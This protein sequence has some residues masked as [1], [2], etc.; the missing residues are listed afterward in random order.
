MKIILTLALLF[1]FCLSHAQTNTIKTNTSGIVIYR[2]PEIPAAY[3]GGKGEWF[4][5]LSKN[6]RY[7]Q[8]AIDHGEV[9]GIVI[10]GFIVDSLGHSHHFVSVSGPE[11]LRDEAMRLVKN[12]KIWVPATDSGRIV[13]SWKEQEIKF[14][15]VN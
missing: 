1:C 3:P 4:R 12:V 8:I 9:Q 14:I 5:Y 15:L 13:N 6:L 2:Y 7:P 11:E 10:T